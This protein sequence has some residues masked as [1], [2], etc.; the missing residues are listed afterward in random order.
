MRDPIADLKHE[1]LAA[2]ERQQ[3]HAAAVGAGRR[4]L[5]VSLSRNRV[6][7]TATTVAV[8]AA[9]TLVFT[10]P[11]NNSPG[12]LGRVQAALT[13]PPGTILHA[14]WELTSTSSDLA[15]T[16]THGPNEIWIDQTPPHMYRV[17]LASLDSGAPI[18][19]RLPARAE[20]PSELGGCHE[21]FEPA[22][23]GGDAQVRAAEHADYSQRSRGSCFPVDP[24]KDLRV[25]ISAGRAHD[26]GKT[27]LDGRTVERIRTDP[28]TGCPVSPGCPR[29]PTTRT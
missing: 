28:P 12:F 10:A 2:A 3:P 25:A 13:P 26:E 16:V 27:E 1:L 6:L 23:H 14:K 7:L 22:R 29:K 8:V 9:A 15:C 19:A 18:R 17:L 20:R 21:P 24:V 5:R 4:R 11:W